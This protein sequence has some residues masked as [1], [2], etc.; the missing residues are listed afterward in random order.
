MVEHDIHDSRTQGAAWY[1]WSFFAK[2]LNHDIREELGDAQDV[3]LGWIMIVLNK[4]RDAYM[5]TILSVHNRGGC[6]PCPLM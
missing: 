4:D 1:Q 6:W 3:R 5:K 2:C